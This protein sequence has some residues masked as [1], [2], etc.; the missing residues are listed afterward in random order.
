M[1]FNSCVRGMKIYFY[2]K[3]HGNEKL[4]SFSQETCDF[5]ILANEALIIA[6]YEDIKISIFGCKVMAK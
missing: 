5:Q 1:E 4:E 6:G 3:S 2:L